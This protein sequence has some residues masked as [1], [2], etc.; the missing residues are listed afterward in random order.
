MFKTLK[1][2]EVYMN[3]YETFGDALRNIWRFIE[4]VYNKKR[5]HSSLGYR[6]PE[7]F[8]MEVAL[9]TIA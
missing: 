9:N 7:Q 2:E 5:L 1:V 8:E 6:S 4:K 3:E